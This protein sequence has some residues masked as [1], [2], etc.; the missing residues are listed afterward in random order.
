MSPT[1]LRPPG[2]TTLTP[3]QLKNRR[4]RN[5]AIGLAVAFLAALFYAIT[6]VKIGP[7]ILHPEP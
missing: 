2:E 6:I 3:A 1:S 5:I 7:A 4:L